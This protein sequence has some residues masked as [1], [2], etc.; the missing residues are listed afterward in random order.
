MKNNLKK[1]E[2]INIISLLNEI[3]KIP[4]PDLIGKILS[5]CE[6]ND[7]DVQEIGEFL[8]ESEQFKKQLWVDAVKHNQVQDES[9][10]K[11]INTTQ[12]L[13]AW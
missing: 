11:K 3:N 7:F 13:D 12:E 8:S 6:Q 9:L 5:Y 4:E 2:N 10:R 1:I